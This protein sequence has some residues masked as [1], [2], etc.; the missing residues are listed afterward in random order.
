MVRVLSVYDEGSIVD[1]S[2]IGAK[3]FSVLIESEGRRVLFDTGLRDRYL[4]HNLE[5]LEVGYDSVE[6]VVVSQ[7][8]PDNCCAINGFLDER[9]TKVDVYAPVGLYAGKKSVLSRKAGLSD[10]NREKVDLHD[11]G[12]WME[13]IPKVWVSPPIEYGNGKSESFIVIDGKK[14]TIVSPRGMYGPEPMISATYQKFGRN[15]NAFV[16]S[17]VLERKKK[18]VAEAYAKALESAGCLDIHLNHAT[19]YDGI[20]KMRVYFGL[21]RIHDFFVGMTFEC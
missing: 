19:G 21:D 17:M 6:A 18:P 13:V 9:T 14:L 11:L 10:E 7:S 3:G 4:K 1:T 2:L 16:G 8:T 15:P 20:S 12:E 5:F